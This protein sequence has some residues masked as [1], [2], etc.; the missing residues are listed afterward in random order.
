MLDANRLRVL[1]EIAHAGSIAAAAERLSFTPPA[2]SQQLTKLEREVGCVLVERGRTGATLTEAGRVLLEHGERVLGELRDAEAAI[3]AHTGTPPDHLSL[4]AFAS[5]GKILLPQ[6]L[7]AFGREHPHVRLSLA[8]IEPPGG[9]DLVTS[10]D[11]DLLVTHRYP[12]VPLPR[13]SGLHRERVLVDPLMVV[14][15]TGHP[16][17][18]RPLSLADLADEEWIC[19][20]PGIANRTTLDTAAAAAGVRLT[21]AY[22]TRDYEVAL[23]LIEVGVGVALIPSTILGAARRGGWVSR[24]LHGARLAREVYVVHRRRPP[25]PLPELV[26]TL[27]GVAARALEEA[28]APP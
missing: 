27:R 26:S 17:A 13:A 21:V 14:A 4:G 20:A 9:H 15:P 5:A 25:E 23:A 28:P 24:P 10:G 3:R 8:D 16:V 12:A 7:A 2:L 11:L 19:G 1:V 22:E 18:D 6:T